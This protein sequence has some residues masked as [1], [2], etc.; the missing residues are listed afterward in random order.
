[1]TSKHPLEIVR[2]LKMETSGADIWLCGGGAMAATLHNE[3]DQ[4]I[5]KRNPIALGAGISLFGNT[6][7]D[8]LAFTLTSTRTFDSGV[9]ISTL[10]AVAAQTRLSPDRP[11]P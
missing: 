7:F 4:L 10:D 1:M 9:V 11:C 8:P 2:D 5:L 6:L 3:I